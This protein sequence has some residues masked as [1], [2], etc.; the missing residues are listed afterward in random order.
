MNAWKSA[1]LSATIVA[2]SSGWAAAAPAVVLE[3][4]NLRVGPGYGFGIIA[5]IPGGWVVD[6]GACGDGW[7]QVNAGGMIGYVDATYLGIAQPPAIAYGPRPYYWSRGPYDGRYAYSTFP[8]AGYPGA[9]YDPN[10]AYLHGY[11][12]DP[13]SAGSFASAYAHERN[14]GI[15]VDRRVAA[16]VK[17]TAVAKSKATPH[18]NVTSSAST[19]GAAASAL[20]P[21]RADQDLP[22]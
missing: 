9:G 18:A 12:D 1:A 2:L 4:L 3:Y 16:P 15:R 5:V 19:T 20:R 17:S 13:L 11:D 7:C 10:Y 8:Y 14:T 21:S 6:A 22:R